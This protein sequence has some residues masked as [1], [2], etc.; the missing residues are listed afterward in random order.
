MISIDLEIGEAMVDPMWPIWNGWFHYSDQ[1][2]GMRIKINNSLSA[3]LTLN[4]I[5]LGMVV[6]NNLGQCFFT[7]YF[8]FKFLNYFLFQ[9]FY[10][11]LNIK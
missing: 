6:I 8:T 2:L 1:W 7:E 3:W 9:I 10:K 4:M 5:C 11:P